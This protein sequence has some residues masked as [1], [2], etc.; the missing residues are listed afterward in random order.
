MLPVCPPEH[1]NF[2]AM[3]TRRSQRR[4]A[5]SPC[6][7]NIRGKSK[8]LS[9]CTTRRSASVDSYTETSTSVWESRSPGSAVCCRDKGDDL[10]AEQ[11]L[12]E[13]L[14]ITRDLPGPGR[15][16][17][18]DTRFELA[19]ILTRRGQLPEAET[20]LR[21]TI[22]LRREQDSTGGFLIGTA[23]E[24]LTQ[25]LTS[26]GKY[27]EAEQ[28]LQET[29]EAFAAVFP[30][31][32]L[33]AGTLNTACGVWYRQHA[34]L[35]KAQPHFREAIRIFRAHE[36]PP[37]D[38][39]L[40]ALDGLFS[41]L[42]LQED[43][44]EETIAVFY[45]WVENMKYASGPDHQ[46]VTPYYFGFAQKLQDRGHHADAIPVLVEGIRIARQVQGDQW[47]DAEK[48]LR[49]LA[50]A[51][52]HVGFDSGLAAEQYRA[53]LQGAT[54]LSANRPDMPSFTGLLGIIHYRLGTYE[55]AEKLLAPREPSE[56]DLDEA[57]RERAFLAMTQF[58]LGQAA[59]AR[60]TLADV[61]EM[62]K[63]ETLAKD[64]ISRAIVEQAEALILPAE[65]PDG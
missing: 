19:Q 12:R 34:K 50:K 10:A 38:Y 5:V 59:A 31:D 60:S 35:E 47:E 44:T 33:R 24:Q 54:I 6:N 14:E 41:L 18:C 11:A 55:E 46:L 7:Y 37:R 63:L 62:M 16:A 40:A 61:R 23:L 64:D 3:T 65:R 15:F 58:Q 57:V 8:R 27:D 1:G 30:P 9:R 45:E 32:S 4:S 39:Y 53:A 56:D 2:S 36:N 17:S 43:A 29:F 28:M 25:V 13:G 49:Q 48:R 51:T 42:V 22:R 52:W 21:D 26:Q 20:L